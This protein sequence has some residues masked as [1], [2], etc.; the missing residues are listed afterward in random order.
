MGFA[1]Y[2]FT[3]NVVT[4]ASLNFLEATDQCILPLHVR[5][6]RGGEGQY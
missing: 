6:S 4:M 5:S 1:G 2:Q 3:R